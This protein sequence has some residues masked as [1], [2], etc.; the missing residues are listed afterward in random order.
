MSKFMTAVG[1]IVWGLIAMGFVRLGLG[2]GYLSEEQILSGIVGGIC[3]GW[4]AWYYV[5]R[6][7]KKEI[8]VPRGSRMGR[9]ALAG[10]LRALSMIRDRTEGRPPDSAP[11]ESKL[12][13]LGS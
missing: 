5:P 6:L 9:A 1:V 8:A 3:G 7:M 13:E 4:G 10:D 12:R 11:E 2:L